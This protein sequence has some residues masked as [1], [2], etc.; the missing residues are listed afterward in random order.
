[1]PLVVVA[2]ALGCVAFLPLLRRIYFVVQITEAFSP[3]S[4]WL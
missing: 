4:S 2:G 3:F 1:M